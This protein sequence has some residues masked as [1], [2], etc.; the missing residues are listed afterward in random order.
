MKYTTEEALAEIMRRSGQIIMQRERRACRVLS[1]ITAALF[2]VLVLMI[3]GMQG[4]PGITPA[5]SVYGAFLLSQ[6]AGGYVLASV[7][8]FTL[9]VAVT[10]LSPKMK[11]QNLQENPDSQ[12]RKDHFVDSNSTPKKTDEVN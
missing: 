8:A 10:L 1:G 12:S 9:G 11:K 5:G 3:A 4:K 2:A 7:I 6:E